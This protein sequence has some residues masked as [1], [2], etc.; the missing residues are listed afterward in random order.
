MQVAFGIATNKYSLPIPSTC[1]EE[2]SQ[3]MTSIFIIII[4]YSVEFNDFFCL[5]DCWQIL[6]QER[7]TFSDLFEQINIIIETNYRTNGINHMEPNEESYQSLQKDWREEIQD[8]FKELKDKEQV[9]YIYL[10]L[11]YKQHEYIF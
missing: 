4:F 6:P 3:L 2:F 9:K 11:P 7:P 1:P 8:M 5:K 10:L